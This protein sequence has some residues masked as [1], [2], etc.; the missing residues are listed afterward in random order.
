[1][2][3]HTKKQTEITT[4]YIYRVDWEPGA[5]L[6]GLFIATSAALPGN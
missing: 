1:M 6:P 5:A 4:S 2:I 3:R